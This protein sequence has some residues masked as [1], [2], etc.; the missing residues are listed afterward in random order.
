MRPMSSD[1]A[2][3]EDD[4]SWQSTGDSASSK[5]AYVSPEQR[6]SRRLTSELESLSIERENANLA[7]QDALRLM[8]AELDLHDLH[9][10]G[11]GMH[12]EDVESGNSGEPGQMRSSI[13]SWREL[14]PTMRGTSP[15]P[16]RWSIPART[17]VP[18]VN[19]TERYD[20]YD[21]STPLYRETSC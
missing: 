9:I 18:A 12:E 5:P 20:L 11:A 4:F 19:E 7:L 16:D 13:G 10:S 1:R 6:R 21:L 2:P 17:S 14:C 15:M 3:P 8:H